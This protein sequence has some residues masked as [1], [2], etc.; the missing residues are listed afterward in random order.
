MTAFEPEIT[1]LNRPYWEALGSGSLVFQRCADCG[2]CW[3]PARSECPSCWSSRHAWV[4]A[5]GTGRLI[6]WV[7]YHRAFDKAFADRLPYNVALVELTEGPRLYTS[8]LGDGARPWQADEPVRLVVVPA[9]EFGAPY[10]EPIGG[11]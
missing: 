6:S 2:H 1:E 4:P 8:L 5:A 3:L 9:G 11:E 10:F 7:V